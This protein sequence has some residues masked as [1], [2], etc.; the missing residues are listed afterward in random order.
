MYRKLLSASAVALALLP[1]AATALGLGGIRTQSALNEPFVGHIEL[2]DVNPDELDNVKVALASEQ[3]FARVGAERAYFLTRLDFRPQVG[4]DGRTRVRISSSEPVREPFLDFVVEVT[5][6]QGRLVKEYTVLLDPPVTLNRRAPGV[7]SPRI[8]AR[9]GRRTARPTEVARPPAS[10]DTSMFP[11]RHGPVAPGT[12]LWQIARAM[13]PATGASINQTA[14]ALYRSN[15]DAFIGGDIDLL[16][17]GAVLAIPSASELFALDPRSAD[18]E[19]RAAVRGAPVIAS[20]LTDFA[21]APEPEDRLAIAGAA[22]PADAPAAQLQASL[23]PT[24]AASA[25]DPGLGAIERNLLLV[26]E[27]GESTRQETE[28]LRNRIRE[29]EAQLTDIQTLLEISNQRVAELQQQEPTPFEAL[30]GMEGPGGAPE[31]SIPEI[32]AA[33]VEEPDLEQPPEEQ[34]PEPIARVEPEEPLDF[35]QPLASPQSQPQPQPGEP[36]QP[37]EPLSSVE[38][39]APGEGEGLRPQEP[40][41]PAEPPQPLEPPGPD[42]RLASTQ[43]EPLIA[44]VSSPGGISGGTTGDASSSASDEPFW[45]SLLQPVPAL[46]MGTVVAVFLIALAFFRRQRSLEEALKPDELGPPTIGRPAV[47]LELPPA[48]APVPVPAQPAAPGPATSKDLLRP[49][50]GFGTLGDETEDV[51]VVAEADVYLT[52]GRYREAATVLEEEIEKSPD[53]L[54]V[55]YK[56]AEAYHGAGNLRGMEALM[57]HMQQAG[58][59]RINPDQWQRLEDMLLDLQQSDI[60]Q[61]MSPAVD[62]APD[63]ALIEPTR[64]LDIPEAEARGEEDETGLTLVKSRTGYPAVDGDETPTRDDLELELESLASVTGSGAVTQSEGLL[65]PLTPTSDLDLDLEDLDTFKEA[66]LEGSSST[67]SPAMPLSEDLLPEIPDDSRLGSQ[68]GEGLRAQ[69]GEATGEETRDSLEVDLPS[70]QW[71]ADANLWDEVATKMDLARAYLE[72][73]DPEAARGILEEVVQE[74]NEAQRAE[75]REMIARLV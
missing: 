32:D 34:P 13:A 2:L 19:F 23:P 17:V 59:D 52:Y 28:E 11:L 49:Y 7:E 25:G 50:S 42:E 75:A 46:V 14:M 10:V 69:T 26:Q 63:L 16:R 5:W 72:M 15:Q 38:P 62:E 8:A 68:G 56:L 41:E 47:A 31:A 64:R 44:R 61:G 53:R 66:E 9:S 37:D 57:S 67:V 27:A 45:A 54:D 21:T 1:G 74:G 36:P 70:S 48:P 6:P 39:P 51:D 55:K 18:Q 29:L 71:Q 73:E 24:A 58:A 4:P 65:E 35:E 40:S 60:A 30:G 20:P 12:G 33:Q 22:G 43:V 3:E